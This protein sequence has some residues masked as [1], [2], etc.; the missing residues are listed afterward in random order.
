MAGPDYIILNSRRDITS[1]EHN[2]A[3][4]DETQSR[5]RQQLT[6]G[7]TMTDSNCNKAIGYKYCDQTQMM[8]YEYCEPESFALESMNVFL[9]ANLT[10]VNRQ[11]L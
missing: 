3:D 1:N 8:G 10:E 4:F 7:L 5:K 2:L 11:N 9:S 6:Q